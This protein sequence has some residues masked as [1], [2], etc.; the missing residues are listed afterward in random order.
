MELNKIMTEQQSLKQHTT[1]LR[2]IIKRHQE[3]TLPI[4]EDYIE[5][6]QEVVMLRETIA[7]LQL[8]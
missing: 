4:E 7:E 5:I 8:S 3:K 1:E 2:K 6:R